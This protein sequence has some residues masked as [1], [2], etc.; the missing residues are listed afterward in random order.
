MYISLIF[1]IKHNIYLINKSRLCYVQML[2]FK[3]YLHSCRINDCLLGN[4]FL[5]NLLYQFC[6]EIVSYYI[7]N[8]L[9]TYALFKCIIMKILF[10]SLINDQVLN[11]VLH[12]YLL[13]FERFLINIRS[14]KLCQSFVKNY[15]ICVLF[16]VQ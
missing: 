8:F 16:N 14:S 2:T 5:F 1:Y 15:S 9:N 6:F 7:I 12:I 4:L 3:Y 10:N 11:I 13:V